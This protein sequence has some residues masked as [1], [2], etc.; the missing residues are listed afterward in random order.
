M[1]VIGLDPGTI[2]GFA[3]WDAQARQLLEVRSMRVH[4]AMAEIGQRVAAGQ[5]ALILFE[6]ARQRRWF[7]RMDREQAKYGSAVREGAGS[8]KREST[9]WQDYLTSIDVPFLAKPPHRTK[10]SARLFT[11]QTGWTER[12]NNHARDAAMIVHGLNVPMVTALIR[13]FHDR[14][15]RR[16]A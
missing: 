2:T 14:A 11:L 13:D 1:N 16:R 8:A 7:G 12:T 3:T 9:L 15:G 4:E 6:D 5:V 10:V